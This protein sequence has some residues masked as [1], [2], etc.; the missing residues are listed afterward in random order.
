[1]TQTWGLAWP[2]LFSLVGV[3]STIKYYVMGLLRCALHKTRVSF[4]FA[5]S[6]PT[7]S[8]KCSFL[9]PGLSGNLQLKTRQTPAT[10]DAGKA[11]KAWKG[12]WKALGAQSPHQKDASSWGTKPPP[13]RRFILGTQ[14]PH[15]K[16]AS[17]WV[18]HHLQPQFHRAARAKGHDGEQEQQQKLGEPESA[19][20]FSARVSWG[21][22]TRV[23]MSS[24]G[25]PLLNRVL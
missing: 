10:R 21:L 16:E 20:G 25:G 1:M 3:L 2:I 6:R 9:K 13:K 15:Q 14:S 17:S 4:F 23:L 8:Y 12:A 18:H 5:L 24:H 22:R 7:G 11:W 19:G